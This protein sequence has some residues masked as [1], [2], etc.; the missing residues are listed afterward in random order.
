MDQHPCY[1]TINK[2]SLLCDQ[3]LFDHSLTFSSKLLLPCFFRNKVINY[4]FIGQQLANLM[5]N[6]HYG[7]ILSHGFL[8]KYYYFLSLMCIGQSD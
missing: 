3:D 7:K 5:I 2:K 6:A 1:C 4:V 8:K